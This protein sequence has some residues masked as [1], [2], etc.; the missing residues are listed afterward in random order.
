MV[1]VAEGLEEVSVR[2]VTLRGSQGQ[3]GGPTG[4]SSLHGAELGGTVLAGGCA[5]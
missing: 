5:G 2:E 3:A 1:Q 4:G